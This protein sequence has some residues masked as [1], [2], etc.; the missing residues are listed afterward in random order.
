MIRPS[1]KG[2]ALPFVENAIP[3]AQLDGLVNRD[4]RIRGAAFLG[5]AKRAI[6][7]AQLRRG[8]LLRLMLPQEP[9]RR[10]S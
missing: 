5:A 3:R 2:V 9:T 6:E 7:A 10:R 8:R 1:V 4:F